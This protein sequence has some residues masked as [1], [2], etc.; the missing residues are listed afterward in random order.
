MVFNDHSHNHVVFRFLETQQRDTQHGDTQHG[1]TQHRQPSQSVERSLFRSQFIHEL[2]LSS[3]TSSSDLPFTSPCHDSS[4][5]FSRL[6]LSSSASSSLS[7]SSLLNHPHH[8]SGLVDDA[9]SL[10]LKATHAGDE[11]EEEEGEGEEEEEEEEEEEDEED[12]EEEYENGVFNEA[13]MGQFLLDGMA[14]GDH[15]ATRSSLSYSL[16]QRGLQVARPP[17]KHKRRLDAGETQ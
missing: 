1:D 8:R 14:S 11:D 4:T 15:L 13:T 16:A 9:F 10:P 6:P 12:E 2:F 7:S 3:D 5:S 17:A